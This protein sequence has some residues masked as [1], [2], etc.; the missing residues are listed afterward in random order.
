MIKFCR[1]SYF[2]RMRKLLLL[3]PFIS[4]SLSGQT[5]NLKKIDSIIDSTIKENHPGLGVGIIKNGV[6]VYEY[7]RG[8]SNLQHQIPF[9]EKTRSNIASTAKQFTALMVLELSLNQKRSLED[10]VRKYILLSIKSWK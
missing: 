8:L 2:Y 1:F 4:L 5:E 9:S 7:Y 3:I 6:V 10:D